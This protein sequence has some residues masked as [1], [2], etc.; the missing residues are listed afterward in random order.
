MERLPANLFDRSVIGQ[1]ADGVFDEMVGVESSELETVLEEIGADSA[2]SADVQRLAFQLWA[3]TAGEDCDRVAELMVSRGIKVH[4]GHIRR[5]RDSQSWPAIA[6][7]VRAL[8]S[9]KS[10]QVV[11]S[12]LSIGMVRAMRWAISAFNDPSVSPSVKLGLARTLWDRG[13]LPVHM[14][15]D[16]MIGAMFGGGELGEWDDS[17]LDDVI[18]RYGTG[19]DDGS[20]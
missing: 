10:G 12:M 18:A 6:G 4:A 16:L 2:Y 11:R 13:G 7:E 8:V 14:R 20:G 15:G 3:F 9:H 17:A 1:L 5:W 19:E